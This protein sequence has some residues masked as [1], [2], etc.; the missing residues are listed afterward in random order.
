L[1]YGFYVPFVSLPLH[2][3]HGSLFFLFIDA[4]CNNLWAFSPFFPLENEVQ[5][6]FWGTCNPKTQKMRIQ[7]GMKMESDK[8]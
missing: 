3:D 1:D 7:R 6:P 5:A 8:R 2:F 4:S